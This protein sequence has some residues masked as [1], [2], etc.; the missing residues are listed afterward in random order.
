[1][2]RRFASIAV[3]RTPPNHFPYV[4]MIEGL[5][6]TVYETGRFESTQAEVL[7]WDRL[8]VYERDRFKSCPHCHSPFKQTHGKQKYCS[9]SCKLKA[10]RKRKKPN[11]SP[12]TSKEVK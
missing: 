10:Y 5:Y 7:L 4:E 8:A 9:D 1:M 12:T 2:A 11:P 6:W 3:S